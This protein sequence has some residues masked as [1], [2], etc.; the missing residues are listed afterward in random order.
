MESCGQH[1][2][3]II[4]VRRRIDARI[5]SDIYSRVHDA[6][7]LSG[8]LFGARRRRAMERADQLLDAVGL[9]GAANK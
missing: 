5:V 2:G 6:A 4:P 1:S 9:M 3:L 8:R 7:S